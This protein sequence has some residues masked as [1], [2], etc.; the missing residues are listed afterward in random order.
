VL[1]TAT[2]KRWIDTKA[3]GTEVLKSFGSGVNYKQYDFDGG[4]YLGFPRSH[5]VW[6][7]G[8]VVIVPAPGHTP[9]SV[10][11]FFMSDVDLPRRDFLAVLADLG[12]TVMAAGPSTAKA[13]PRR[14]DLHHHPITP[15]WLEAV[16]PDMPPIY[17]DKAR[18]VA[19]K[20]FACQRTDSC[21]CYVTKNI[22]SNSHKASEHPITKA[23]CFDGA[24]MGRF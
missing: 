11:V 1:V 15:E 20:C 2:G 4:P 5:D 12:L 21:G 22:R 14:I 10:V 23:R 13:A 9:D 16:A 8:S 7:D 18:V 6:D 17:V 3:K 24:I 19:A